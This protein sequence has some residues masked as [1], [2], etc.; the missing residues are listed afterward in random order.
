MWSAP[1]H[2]SWTFDILD[3]LVS[4]ENSL[5]LISLAWLWILS[6]IE[7]FQVY[8]L[9]WL[10]LVALGDRCGYEFL[11]TLS[12]C[13]H[14]DGLDVLV[15]VHGWLQWSCEGSCAF[16]DR[17]PKAT[18]VHCSC[19]WATSLVGRF[20]RCPSVWMRFVQH[21]LAVEPPSAGQHNRD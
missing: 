10:H 21:L 6:E 3:I 19:H 11:V 16:S 5:P 18:L 15:I 2:F 12:S 14:L 20:L 9:E 13:R 17:A 8:L 7:W 4:W 1:R